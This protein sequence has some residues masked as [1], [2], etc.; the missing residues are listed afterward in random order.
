MRGT[1]LMG[2]TDLSSFQLEITIIFLFILF[3]IMSF[4]VFYDSDNYFDGIKK[5]LFWSLTLITGPIGLGIYF[6]IRRK[7]DY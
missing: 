5:H 2:G 3:C 7:V 4:W 6:L 1:G